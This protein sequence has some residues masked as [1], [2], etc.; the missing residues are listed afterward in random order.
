[1]GYSYEEL[2]LFASKYIMNLIYIYNY[3][4][5]ERAFAS[6]NKLVC[7][8]CASEN[9]VLIDFD[10]YQEKPVFDLHIV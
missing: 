6:V 7:L 10:R 2:F 9:I 5:Y 4:L 1:M 3:K 8:A